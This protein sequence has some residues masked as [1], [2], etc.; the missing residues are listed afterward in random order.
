MLRLA[1]DTAAG[2]APDGPV[3]RHNVRVKGLL[4]LVLFAILAATVAI[5]VRVAGLSGVA[6]EGTALSGQGTPYAVTGVIIGIAAIVVL[7]R[8]RVR[9]FGWVLAAVALFWALDGLAQSYV[10]VAMLTDDPLPAVTFA[11]WFLYRFTA[12]LPVT[13][14]ALPLLF[15]AG[16]FLPGLWGT[17]GR[18][19]IAIMV[20][21]AVA[22]TVFPYDPGDAQTPV[23]PGADLNPTT[24]DALE[25]L[26]GIAQLLFVPS[27]VLGFLVPVATVVVRYRR[28][29]GVERDR[30]RWLLWSVLTAA[31]G[32]AASLLVQSDWLLAAS[33]FL[34][35]NVVP[36]AMAIGVVQPSLVSIEDLLIRTVVF[37]GLA[38]VLVVIDLAVLASLAFILDDALAQRT[39]VL[40][41]LLVSIV[42][43]GPLRARLWAWVRRLTFGDRDQPFDVVAGLASTLE[44][45]DDGQ[46]QLAAV[47]EAVSSAF[48]VSYV[49]ID[50]QGAAGERLVV[51]RGSRPER[52]RTLPISY[53][54]GEVGRLV[55]PAR[56]LRS[57]LSSRDERLLADLV[58]QAATASRTAR[59]ADEVQDSRERLVVAREEERRRIRRDLHDGLG[60][61][62]GGVVFQLESARLLVESDPA[63]A[64]E[65]IST[66]STQLQDVVA[67]VR[68]LV[69]DLRPPALDD[70]G[71]VGALRQ[72]AELL[73]RSGIVTRVDAD[74][75]VDLPA[76]VEVAAYR[77]A[78]EAM[79]NVIRHARASRCH[80]VVRRNPREVMVEVTDDGVGIATDAEV[81]VGLLSLRE[82]AAELGGRSEV[83]CPAGGGTR[84]RAWLPLRTEP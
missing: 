12:L 50:V 45:L 67:D 65:A 8:G 42:L 79:T 34:A 62:L 63:A 78:G 30:E 26:S 43:Y 77:I 19:T 33:L 18:L 69:H 73:D 70:R 47:A 2:S 17:L 64:R 36:V 27:L 61:S 28:A 32:V 1:A 68:R 54:G 41:V 23:P 38:L 83:T 58:R 74:D 49:Q 10:R 55:L 51:T 3:Q 5:E 82:R 24:I 13:I 40:V 37:G 20:L 25:P 14:V 84:V 39:V 52:V 46:A 31:I 57:R 4:A 21:N 16:R 15:P 6:F 71:L 75:V 44:S 11:V 66:T 81:G 60:P 59:L 22:L 80:V 53:R 72:Q 56:G 35:V 76:A 9:G 48:G 7:H 29:D